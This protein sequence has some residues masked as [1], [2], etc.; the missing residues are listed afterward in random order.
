MTDFGKKFGVGDMLKS[1]YD[2]DE[3][4]V[5]AVAQT[6][7]DMTK[8]VYDTADDGFVD[9]L[10]DHA[11]LHED[12]GGEEIAV[13]GLVGATARAI[14]G[15]GTAGRVMRGVSLVVDDGT[16][17][18]TLKCTVGTL[19]NGDVIAEVDNIGKD[20]TTGDFRLDS[21]GG[22]LTI[23]NTGLT[24]KAVFGF[25]ELYYNACG[26]PLLVSVIKVDAGL[27]VNFLGLS[28]GTA[29]DLTAVVSTGIIV[30][31]ILYITDE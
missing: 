7:A 22:L 29:Q 9:G 6:E 23:L 21:S 16:D 10:K 25:A 12:G 2:S 26:T 27:Q 20:A 14:L 31:H 24:G 18:S 28:N 1:V 8:A 15:D 30:P 11:E 17:A 3:D 5:I 4:G 19:W 13:T